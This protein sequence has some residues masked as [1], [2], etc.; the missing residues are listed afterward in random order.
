MANTGLILSL[1]WNGSAGLDWMGLNSIKIKLP[2]LP[3]RNEDIDYSPEGLNE[4]VMLST[5]G[6]F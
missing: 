6:D 3:G 1:I 2:T 5:S 4:V